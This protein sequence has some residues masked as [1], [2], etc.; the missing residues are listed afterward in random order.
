LPLL[1]L[2]ASQ[3]STSS[4]TTESLARRR[5][6]VGAPPQGAVCCW[7]A[8]QSESPLCY[9]ACPP[10]WENGYGE[11]S[12]GKV[13]GELPDP[14]LFDTVL[15][16]RVLA[17]RCRKYYT[18]VRLHRAL[19]YRRPAPEAAM[20]WPLGAALPAAQADLTS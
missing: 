7:A 1:G 3:R 13:Q 10:C 5:V 18:A 19:G 9:D 11:S 2:P 16:A 15:E 4:F 20:P 8:A 6:R 17:G 12:N 14:E